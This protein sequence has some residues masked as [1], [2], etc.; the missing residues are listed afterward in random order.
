MPTTEETWAIYDENWIEAGFNSAEEMAEAY[1]EGKLILERHVEEH[2]KRPTTSQTLFVERQLKLDM[3]EFE[4]VG[5]LDRV[6]QHEDGTLEI[7]DY[8]SGRD[9]VD[10]DDVKFDLALGCYQLLLRHKFPGQPVKATVIAL[11]TGQSATASLS[12]E[13]LEELA[14]D[15]HSLGLR[16]LTEEFHEIFPT[17]KQI[18]SRCDF[19]PLCRK[20]EEFGTAYLESSQALTGVEV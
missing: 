19:I 13:E 14:G 16:I 17:H 11:R 3:E 20:H 12:N 4:L 8:K 18:C 1:G 2:K 7:I 15:L 9:S 6:D 5:R 10:Q